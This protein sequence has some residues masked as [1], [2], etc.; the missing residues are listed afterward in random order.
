MR[1]FR[2]R[3][4]APLRLARVRKNQ[5]ARELSEIVSRVTDL[6]RE[7]MELE[8]GIEES[9]RSILDRARSGIGGADLTLLSRRREALKSTAMRLGARKGELAE[10]E[11]GVRRQLAEVGREMRVLERLQ[12]EERRAHALDADRLEQAEI[13]EMS[14]KR[15]AHLQENGR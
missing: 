4:A 14:G 9:S 3:L 12:D 1:E 2:F 6:E 11:F 5:L 13:D 10:Q 15:H 8:Q 7:M